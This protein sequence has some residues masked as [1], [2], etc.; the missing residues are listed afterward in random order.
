MRPLLAALVALAALVPAAC[1]P[2]AGGD[3]YA[4]R[5]G[6][7]ATLDAADAALRSTRAAQA[8]RVQAAT[9]DAERTADAAGYAQTQIAAQQTLDAGRYT[10]AAAQQTLDAARITQTAEW[11]RVTEDH[12]LRELTHELAVEEQALKEL[13]LYGQYTAT[14][15]ALDNEIMRSGAVSAA[16][17]LLAITAVLAIAGGLIAVILPWGLRRYRRANLISAP[18]IYITYGNGEVHQ[19]PLLPERAERSRPPI[20]I[21]G[22]APKRAPA[23][24]RGA[25]RLVLDAVQVSADGWDATRIPGWR[26]LEERGWSS[27]TWQAVV[28]DLVTDGAVYTI[29]RQGTFLNRDRY[30]TLR[31]LLHDLI[32]RERKTPSSPSPTG[33]YVQ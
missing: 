12:R 25:L 27:P 11:V 7:N 26:D 5:S 22:P 2:V 24:G 30:P 4:S 15:A 29:E 32:R 19:F 8:E 1:A 3:P 20:V 23:E 13:A 17:G 6:A 9:M 10:Q 28:D 16:W 14:A 21:N 33:S 31:D 18:G